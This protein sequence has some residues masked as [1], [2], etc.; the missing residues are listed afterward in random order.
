VLGFGWH[1]P[2]LKR[3]EEKMKVKELEMQK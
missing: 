2:G 3:S 1:T